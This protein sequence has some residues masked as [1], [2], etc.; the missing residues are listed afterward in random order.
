MLKLVDW[1]DCL[2]QHDD[3]VIWSRT[4]CS[5]KIVSMKLSVIFKIMKIS[6]NA[7]VKLTKK[8]FKYYYVRQ[9]ND[10]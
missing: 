8:T 10:T 4:C 3:D 9:A 2:L 5:C 7:D 6:D 1:C